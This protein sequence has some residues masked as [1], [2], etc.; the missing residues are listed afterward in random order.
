MCSDEF[1]LHVDNVRKKFD[2]YDNP[3]DR[4]KEIL[5]APVR[6]WMGLPKKNY[7]REFWAL[8]NISFSVK[9]GETVGIVGRNGAGKSTLLQII[10]GT[11]SPTAGRV[12]TSGRIS[13]LLELGAGFNPE[14][15][16]RDN[17]LLNSAILGLSEE[18][19]L[20]RLGEIISFADIG[21]FINQP[22]KTYSSGM[23]VRLAFSVAIHVQPELLIIDEA[24]AVGDAVFQSKCM[25]RLRRMMNDGVSLLF[26]SHDIGAVKSLC[27]K[28][29]LI[30]H[31][32]QIAWGETS[33]VANEYTRIVHERKSEDVTNYVDDV[34]Q[35]RIGDKSI[36]FVRVE[37]FDSMGV[38]RDTFS[39]GESITLKCTLKA[40]KNINI[41]GFGLHVRDRAGVDVGYVDNV[42]EKKFITDV[43]AGDFYQ[44]TWSIPV[45]FARG[46]YDIA[47]VLS[48]PSE[49]VDVA[50]V[51]SSDFVIADFLP[52]SAQFKVIGEWDIYGNARIGSIKDVRYLT[53][54][55]DDN[56]SALSEAK[57]SIAEICS[58]DHPIKLH[59]ACG[60]NVLPGWVNVDT[61]ESTSVYACDLASRLPFPDNR[62]E[63]IF[64]EHFLEHL[65]RDE[66]GRFLAECRRVLV[67]GG[68]LRIST[69]SLAYL[70]EC[71]Q[72]RR[73]TEWSDLGWVTDKGADMLNEGMRSWGHQYL[74]DNEA[75][76]HALHSAGF[77]R[78]NKVEWRK[79]DYTG[80]NDLECRPYHNDIIYEA[81]K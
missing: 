61:F 65:A 15:S 46:R 77:L 81:I 37:M 11:L 70:I 42:L 20:D 63:Y 1:I 55:G 57:P 45:V 71:Y 18:E 40:N 23:Y 8:D 2:L 19:T 26:V 4:L 7:H 41:L 50:S 12:S 80:L 73:L 48:A 58:G 69:P 62:V 35:E 5:S 56:L 3:R 10:T 30:E 75:I 24:L 28:A 22:V 17:V 60:A 52:L 21:D 36:E 59:L 66:G 49:G 51:R 9:R 67:A 32:K 54:F 74:Y 6:R 16:G 43:N 25:S 31:G 72:N 44:V 53:N 34:A 27:S 13:A 47:V 76:E 38:S 14:F 39:H 29:V 79:S 78:Y 33:S 68:V 64:C